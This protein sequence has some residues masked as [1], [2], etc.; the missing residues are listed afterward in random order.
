MTRRTTNSDYSSQQ[1]PKL[2]RGVT[3]ILGDLAHRQGVDRRVA[4]HGHSTQAVAHDDVLALPDDGE[5]SFLQR[6]QGVFL[7]EA[8]QF[9]RGALHGDFFVQDARAELLFYLRL[10]VE[11]FPDG[12]LD[13]GDGLLARF[14]LRAAA[15]Q[16]IAPDR[17]TFL[18]LRQ[19][20]AVFHGG[21]IGSNPWRGKPLRQE[22]LASLTCQP[23]R[24]GGRAE[25]GIGGS[26]ICQS[27]ASH[28]TAV[29]NL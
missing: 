7:S 10:R 24:C 22:K 6:P 15:R 18:R 13:V 11:V 17:P 2:L 1:R 27:R 28:R 3:G 25:L 21:R 26:E 4:R 5:V 8:R 12:F 20:D 23:C 9:G 19:R 14:P 16:I 29:K